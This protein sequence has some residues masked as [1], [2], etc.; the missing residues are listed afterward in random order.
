MGHFQYRTCSLDCLPSVLQDMCKRSHRV[1]F[2]QFDNQ[3]AWHKWAVAQ[4]YGP[5]RPV[6]RDQLLQFSRS[7]FDGRRCYYVLDRERVAHIFTE[8]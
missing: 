7:R 6:A 3:V 1:P 5:D 8:T 2:E 4:G